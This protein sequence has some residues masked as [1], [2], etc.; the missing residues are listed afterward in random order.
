MLYLE[1][2]LESDDGELELDLPVTSVCV[3]TTVESG[4][5]RG[6]SASLL[7]DGS[8]STAASSS[9]DAQ[10]DGQLVARVASSSASRASGRAQ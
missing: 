1:E 6:S 3:S 5:M 2:E 8:S 10:L 4:S 9:S 7:G